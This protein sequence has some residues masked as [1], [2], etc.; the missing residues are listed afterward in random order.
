MSE[1]D[2]VKYMFILF[3][4]FFLKFQFDWSSRKMG[5]W[6]GNERNEG[7]ERDSMKIQMLRMV[8]LRI[9]VTVLYAWINWQLSISV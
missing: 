4:I 9:I 7:K 3:H 5:V 8:T 6:V 2:D 1:Y